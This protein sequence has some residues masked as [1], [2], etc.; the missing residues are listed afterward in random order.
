VFYMD[1]TKVDRY[2][3]HVAV[4]I[5][6][7]CKDLFK[8][9]HLFKMYDASI[10]FRCFIYCDAMLQRYFLNVLFECCK[11]RSGYRVVERG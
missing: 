6:V 3:A 5:H 11:T 10:L 1:V 9:F 7:C 4:T 8:I 2:I